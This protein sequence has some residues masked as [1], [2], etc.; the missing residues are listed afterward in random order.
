MVVVMDKDLKDAVETAHGKTKE[1]R[2]QQKV[3]STGYNAG[4][5]AAK[6]INFDKQ[7]GS[8][9]SMKELRACGL[10]TE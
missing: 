1:S 2:I 7:V 4:I 3:S 8:Q 5:N 10:S 6:G 9:A